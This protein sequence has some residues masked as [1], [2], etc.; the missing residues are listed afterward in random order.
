MTKHN[1]KGTTKMKRIK[2]LSLLLV[3][4]LL[5]TAVLTGCRPQTEYEPIMPL[6]EI[7]VLDDD[8]DAAA[9]DAIFNRIAESVQFQF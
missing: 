7:D 8:T 2:L 1:K 4:A 6:D 3:F 5:F 9:H